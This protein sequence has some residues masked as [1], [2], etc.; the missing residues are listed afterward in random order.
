MSVLSL[1][2]LHSALQGSADDEECG[3]SA[4][5]FK[6]LYGAA[7]G[8]GTFEGT[9]MELVVASRKEIERGIVVRTPYIVISVCDPEDSPPQIPRTAG[10]RDVLYLRF[11]DAEPAPGIGLPPEI[12]LMTPDHARAVWEFLRRHRDH[13][14]TVVVHCEQG[15]SRSPVIA[16][17]LC[18][19][20]G[21]DERRFFA[22][23][24]PNRH[25]CSLLLTTATT[26]TAITAEPGRP[27][28]ASEA[29][30]NPHRQSGD[31]LPEEE[32]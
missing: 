6:R 5:S 28:P 27:M 30:G 24:Q 32:Y 12:A 14:G 11:H 19:T 26:Q 8:S 31:S 16:A 2:G 13:V 23:Y 10:L 3:R 1:S 17:A 29:F 15:M 25:V 20:L 9:T 18:R 22:E 21:E 4:E 7:G